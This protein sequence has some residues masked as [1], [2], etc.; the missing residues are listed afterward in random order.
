MIKLFTLQKVVFK[1]TPSPLKVQRIKVKV[2]QEKEVLLC[3]ELG[4][5]LRCSKRSS[6]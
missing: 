3:V 2:L 4:G 1:L 6:K 5:R